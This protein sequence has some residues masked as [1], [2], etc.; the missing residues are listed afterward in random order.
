M[1]AASCGPCRLVDMERE[2]DRIG[3][4]KIKYK[5]RV[6]QVKGSPVKRELLCP[7]VRLSHTTLRRMFLH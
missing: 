1:E 7:T 4:D 6:D 2:R 5:T 3:E